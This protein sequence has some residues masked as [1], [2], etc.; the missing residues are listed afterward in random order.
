MSDKYCVL[1]DDLKDCGVCSLLSI[2]KYYNGDISKEYLRELTLTTK[3]GVS[4]LNLLKAA[5]EI[6][7]EAYGIK[8]EL[9]KINDKNLP[10]IAH[11]IINKK[12]PHFIV[13]Y[14]IN[15][16]KNQVLIMD[17]AIGFKSLS[18]SD[19]DKIT[20]NYFLIMKPKQIIPKL[21]SKNNYREKIQNEITN[22]KNIFLTI[23]L[24]SLFYMILNIIES[25]QFKLLYEDYSN[26]VGSEI[27]I[28]FIILLLFI[29]IKF[30]LNFLRNN[31]INLFNIKL[32]KVLIKDAFYHI[33]NLPYLYYRNHTNGD[34]LTRLND[35]GNIKEL[36]NNLVISML[37]DLV[38]AFVVM[39]F[40]IRIDFHLSLIT[41]SSLL[42]YGI[43]VF[44]NGRCLKKVIRLNYENSA[45]VNNFLVE[46]LTSFETIKNLSIQKYI[47][48][49]FVEKYDSYCNNTKNLIKRINQESF[50]KNTF[51]SIGNLLVIYVGIN[52]FSRNIL[53]LSSLM[54]YI[55]LSNYLVD[56]IRN[57]LN[58]HLQYQN[59]K[60]SITRIKEIY[61]IPEERKIET[62]KSIDSLD[63]NI[64]VNNV[65]YSY[66]GIDNI[67]NN[68]S[69]KILS[70]EKILI[71]GN[72][73]CGKSTL[74]KLLIKYLDGNY[75]GIIKIGGY[76]LKKIDLFSLRNN[77][78]YVSQNEFLY[79]DSVY[80]NITLGKKINYK[81]FL[82]LASNLY[83]DEIV[84]N[85]S[86]V[87]N[88][89]IE[90]NGENISGGEKERI[91]IARSILQKANI[92]I[93]DESF[94][95]LDVEKER[96]ILQ[97]IFKLYP[98][99]TFIIISHRFSNDDLFD[100]KIKVGGGKYEFIK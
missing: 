3:D 83:I 92:Y 22:Y 66:N 6:G 34:L 49:K 20:T 47:Y 64:E 8:G 98:Q 99:K 84:K 33:I 35:L 97:Y 19:F 1:Q 43:V 50:I 63:G 54:T 70:G 13:I 27:K 16:K 76:D 80:E 17:P 29:I 72:S 95:E 94:S 10:V 85:S 15:Y 96:K 71:Y 14:K 79:T 36:V 39:I 73:G 46:S 88:Y 44:I 56:P 61:N 42:L 30:I 5:R 12:Y 77:I 25:Y 65:F 37:V 67:I 55:S 23:I 21:V 38:F 60:A 87:Y 2:I 52:K 7:F 32:D 100:R 82:N 45:I 59:A 78:C 57:L 93:Y 4:A 75:K 40:M 53:S 9:K 18:S 69:F 41:I 74:I 89:V 81:S 90:G 26:N 24:L 51:L 68:L 28:V 11:V 62:N 86:L 31:L 91:I 58:L 48:K